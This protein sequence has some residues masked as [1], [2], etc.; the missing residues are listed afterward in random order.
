MDKISILIPTLGRPEGLKRC[1]NSIR[2]LNY[3]EHLIEVIIRDGE[4]TVPEKIAKMFKGSTGDYIIYLANDT[5]IDPECINEALKLKKRLVSFNEGPLL[6]DNGNICCHF[7]IKKT[8]VYEIGGQIFDTD[9]H[10]VG[11]DNLLW[12]ICDKRGE[13]VWG[14]NAKIIHHHFSK[15]EEMDDIY[16][17]GWKHVEED[18][19]LLQTK[20]SLL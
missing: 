7:M 2:K 20:L 5:E 1:L 19:Q 6:P 4:E 14:E 3:P 16:R 13:A 11:V 8:L 12:A 9:F 17:K 15:G 10:H 18:R